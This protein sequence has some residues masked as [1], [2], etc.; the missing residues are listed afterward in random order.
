[1][2]LSR[3]WSVALTESNDISSEPASRRQAAP[4][5]RGGGGW[6]TV[7]ALLAL[8]AGVVYVAMRSQDL[9]GTWNP[10]DAK[11]LSVLM[12]GRLAELFG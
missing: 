7:I 2:S 5:R 8:L 4:E 11:D 10:M 9:F 12:H 6:L 3:I 1:M